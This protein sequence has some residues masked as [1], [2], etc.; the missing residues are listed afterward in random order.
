MNNGSIQAKGSNALVATVDFYSKALSEALQECQQQAEAIEAVGRQM[1]LH[2]FRERST[3]KLVRSALV[4]AEANKG[5]T[6]MDLS[7]EGERLIRD[8]EEYEQGMDD[9]SSMGDGS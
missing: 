2:A 9:R 4:W 5:K 7:A 1:K 3:A 6:R 8:V